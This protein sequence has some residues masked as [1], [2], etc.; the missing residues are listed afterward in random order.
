MYSSPAELGSAVSRSL[1]M[2]MKKYPAE[3]WVRGQY[4]MTPETQAEM[5]ELRAQ[6]SELRLAAKAAA[7]AELEVPEGLASGE[8]EYAITGTLV[9][10]R[11]SDIKNGLK[12][13]NTR[14]QSEVAIPVK[15]N[16]IFSDLGPV[17][18]NEATETELRNS[19]ARFCA[20]EVAGA[21][22]KLKHRDFGEFHSF[23]MN[24]SLFQDVIV[25]LFALNLI[26][27]GLK[28]RS[29]TDRSKYWA[30]TPLGQDTLMKLRA[31]RKSDLEGH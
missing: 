20:N 5:A 30:L 1:I 6:I 24:D 27:H 8:D 11:K 9:F 16:D 28:K 31:I 3:G 21:P 17:L 26:T 15:W 23:K 19:V 25:Q 13:T 14:Y 7:D 10:Y 18:M 12:T 2:T 29:A 22:M 4:A